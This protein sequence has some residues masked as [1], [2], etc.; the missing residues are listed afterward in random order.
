M[1]VAGQVNVGLATQ[2]GFAVLFIGE[3][4]AGQ[5]VVAERNHQLV[6]HGGW[7]GPKALAGAV[8]AWAPPELRTLFD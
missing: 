8:L 5:W 1:G 2:P 7:R 6:W 3:P 4:A